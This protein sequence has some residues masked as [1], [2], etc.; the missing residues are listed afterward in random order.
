RVDD[1]RM[2]VVGKTMGDSGQQTTAALGASLKEQAVPVA[3][4]A[5]FHP[6]EV[7]LLDA[8]KMRIE[9]VAGN[10]LVVTRAW[11]GSTLAAHNVGAAVYLPRTLEVTR[12]V[13]GTTAAAHSSGATVHRWDPP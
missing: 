3:S 2:I 10:T 1:E 5:G 12:G 6:G 7:I 4:G 8:E 11:D 13:L 9:E